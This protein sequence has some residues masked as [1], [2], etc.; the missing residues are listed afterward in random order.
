MHPHLLWLL[1]IYEAPVQAKSRG[2]GGD[3]SGE[4]KASVNG[5]GAGGEGGGEDPRRCEAS[6]SSKPAAPLFN[7]ISPLVFNLQPP[8]CAL[9]EKTEGGGEESVHTFFPA[10]VFLL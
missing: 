2:G 4:S 9:K 10:S 6:L 8:A 3:Q 1:C 5:V 7:F